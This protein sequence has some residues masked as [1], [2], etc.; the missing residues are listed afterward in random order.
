MPLPPQRGS[1]V[2]PAGAVRHGVGGGGG[3]ADR[4]RPREQ[5]VLP[6]SCSRLNLTSVFSLVRKGGFHCPG[7]WRVFLS[8]PAGAG[9]PREEPERQHGV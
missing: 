1:R 5:R 3:G 7:S 6:V 8:D 9:E 4:A 2:V